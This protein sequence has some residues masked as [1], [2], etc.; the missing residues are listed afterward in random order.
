MTI[1]T[2]AKAIAD[3][4]IAEHGGTATL[5]R[6][7]TTESTPWDEGHDHHDRIRGGRG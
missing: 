6:T 5:V 7:T 4:L 2:R 1:T 3:R